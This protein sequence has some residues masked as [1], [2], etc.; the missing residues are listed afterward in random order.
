MTKKAK[1]VDMAADAT[2][3]DILSG[4]RPKTQVF[5]CVVSMFVWHCECAVASRMRELPQS[6]VNLAKK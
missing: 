1:G 3:M 6:V 4:V 5:T 2:G